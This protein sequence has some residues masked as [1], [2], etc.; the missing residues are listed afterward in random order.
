MKKEVD[1]M[2]MEIVTLENPINM[3]AE[4]SSLKKVTL[5]VST[6]TVVIV[7]LVR[8]V[9]LS[10]KNPLIVIIKTDATGKMF[11]DS[12]IQTLKMVF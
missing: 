12:S 2:V 9:S 11:V 7:L 10:I 5:F 8:N 6:G 1:E 3:M 4:G